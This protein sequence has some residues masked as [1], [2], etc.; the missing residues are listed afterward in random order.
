MHRKFG[1][2]TRKRLLQILI[3]FW[4]TKTEASKAPWGQHFRVKDC[5]DSAL[6]WTVTNTLKTAWIWRSWHEFVIWFRSHVRLVGGMLLVWQ[7]LDWCLSGCHWVG[8]SCPAFCNAA[9]DSAVIIVSCWTRVPVMTL[10]SRH[11]TYYMALSSE[12]HF[13]MSSTLQ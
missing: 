1:C 9:Y 4:E 7:L 5:I 13:M 2:S 8:I 10:T 11:S 12:W 3:F 6:W